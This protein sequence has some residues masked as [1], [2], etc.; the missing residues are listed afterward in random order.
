M[1]Y[2]IL[3][4]TE[5]QSKAKSLPVGEKKFLDRTTNDIARLRHWLSLVLLK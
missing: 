3:S 2:L 5:A 1:V 4:P